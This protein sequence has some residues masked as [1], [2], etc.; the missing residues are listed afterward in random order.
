MKIRIGDQSLRVRI[1]AAEAE[2][3]HQG[4]EITTT[5]HF[6]AIDAFEVVLRTWNLSIGEVHYQANQLIT[7]IPLE[8]SQNLANTRGYTF[9]SEQ[10]GANGTPLSF[11]VEID[12]VKATHA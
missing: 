8:A 5:L 10:L 3:L 2:A 7:S 12:L 11:E 9:R 1:S 6:N 4:K